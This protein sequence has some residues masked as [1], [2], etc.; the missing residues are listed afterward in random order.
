MY[1]QSS[2]PQLAL[3]LANAQ[4]GD[5]AGLL[6]LYDQYYVRLDDG[7]YENSLEA[8]QV[9]SCMDT[10]ERPSVEQDDAEAPEAQAVAPRFGVRTVGDYTCTF[11]PPSIDPR[12]EITGNGA[13][14]IVV[15]GTT[16]DPA[17]PLE[18]SRKM[19]AALEEGRLVVVVGN[20]HTGYG[21][22]DCSSAAV[23]TYLV[24][25]VGHVPAEGLRC[26]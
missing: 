20:R 18:G 23:E 2:W 13:G 10:T 7:T 22:N 4:K 14:P 11:F 12:V 19:A 5:G 8:F 16:G 17:T 26:E 21:V 15:V 9:I 25:P 6:E 1:S 24:D 3:A